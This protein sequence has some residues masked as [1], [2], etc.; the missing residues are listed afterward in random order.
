MTEHLLKNGKTLTLR[1]P[2]KQ[3]AAAMIAYLNQ[4]GGETD[5]L[6]VG[7]NGCRFTVEQEEAFIESINANENSIML[8]G[9]VEDE[10][11]SISTLSTPCNPRMAHNAELAISVK[12][13]YWNA[14]VGSYVMQTLIQFATHNPTITCI[15]LGVYEQN[16]RA[17][18]LYEKFGFQQ[19]GYYAHKFIVN[20]IYHDEILMN[21]YL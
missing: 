9:F 5:F 14:G 1:K 6:L 18:A 13:A 21:L 19:Y 15:H 16:K 3:D 10:L 7:K 4:V 2:T 17:Q 12:Q 20:G 8:L 11:V